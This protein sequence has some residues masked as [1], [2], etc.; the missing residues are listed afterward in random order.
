MNLIPTTVKSKELVEKRREQIVLAAIKLFSKKG[1]Y[2]STLRELSE[3]AGIS[4]GNIYDYVGTKE[5]IFFLLHEYLDRLATDALHRSIKNI[6]DPLEKLRRMVR[7]EFNLMYEWADAILLI[8][9]ECHVLKKP[10]LKQLLQREGSHMR[11]YEQVLE[12]CIQKKQLRD[13]NVRAVANLIKSMADAWVLKRWDLRN[14]LT[15][16]E[17]E[18]AILDLVFFGLIRGSGLESRAIEDTGSLKGKQVLVVNGGT[19]LGGAISSFLFSKNAKVAIHVSGPGRDIGTQASMREKA[20]NVKLY[21][22]KKY[23]P[24]TSHLFKQIVDD[25]GSIDIFIQDLGIS[26]I[27]STAPKKDIHIGSRRLEMNLSCAQDLSSVLED[28]LITRGWGN[29]LYLTPWSWDKHLDP[30]R[31]ETVKAGTIALTR[32]L[33]KRLAPARINVNCIVPGYIG[34]IKN[35]KIQ[36][37]KTSELVK[38]IPMRRLGELPDIL[39]TA[40]FLISGS[41]KYVTGQALA[42]AGGL[43]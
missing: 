39:E 22:E 38:N 4:H 6:D 20:E 1:F 29:I 43:D 3:E 8:Y 27:E 5:D 34:G 10:F 36:E 17:M 37:G 23:G 15:Q 18:K 14:H 25:L 12:E 21:P 28:E 35:L 31:Y 19:V 33:A 32:T 16:L 30:V 2:K 9:Q 26:D 7:T 40:H 41:S 11:L 13:F 24:M 42:V